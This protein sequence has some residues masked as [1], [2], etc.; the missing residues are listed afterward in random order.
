MGPV[1]RTQWWRLA[2]VGSGSLLAN[3]MLNRC[4]ASV[5]KVAD[6]VCWVRAEGN[7]IM[8][9]FWGGNERPKLKSWLKKKWILAS[10]H[11]SKLLQMLTFGPS[12][13]FFLL[14]AFA[15]SRTAVELGGRSQQPTRTQIQSWR[16]F[17]WAAAPTTLLSLKQLPY[18]RAPM[19]AVRKNPM[20]QPTQRKD[21]TRL[22]GLVTVK[23]IHPS[24]ETSPLIEEWMV[25]WRS[26]GEPLS[27]ARP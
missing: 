20:I 13:F 16:M 10:R 14:S 7:P 4:R 11:W 3:N 21:A 5:L 18:S 19:E 9:C 22:H 6:G 26:I 25:Q 15:L 17:F 2:V 8:F 24:Q 12:Q 27:T 23:H 1:T